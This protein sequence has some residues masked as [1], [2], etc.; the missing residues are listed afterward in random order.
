MKK[1]KIIPALLISA[2]VL[3][4]CGGTNATTEEEILTA[5]KVTSVKPQ[6]IEK[7]LVYNGKIE[8]VEQVSV[9]SKLSGTVTSTYKNVGDN[10][11]QGDVL[12]AIDQKDINN[13]INQAK[14]QAN[15]A[16][17][18]VAQAQN[19]YNNVTGAQY[20]QT[21]LQL[22]TS[23]STL[24]NSLKQAQDALNLAKTA[25][26]NA[27]TL[28]S[29]GAMSKTEF[30]RT[31][32]SY[33][34]AVIA[35]DNTT[36]QLSQA[37]D[38]YN[39]TKNNLVAES[40]NSASIGVNQAKASKDSAELALNI[41]SQNLADTTPKSPIS[42]VVSLKNA[43]EGQMIAPSTVAYTISNIDEVTATV[44]VSENIINTLQVGGTVNV[45]INA[46]N[47]NLTGEI[48]EINPV[49]D[50]TS[51]YPIKI[52]LQNPDHEIKPG[53]FCEVTFITEQS[54]NAI[55]LNRE[56]V[57]RNQDVSYVFVLEGENVVSKE[58]T[59]GID[60]GESIEILSGLKAND[61]VVT[62]GQTYVTD[63]EK[64]NVVEEN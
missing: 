35:V 49:A 18:A 15:S 58:V 19:S 6:H 44:K 10:V 48:M 1:I 8:P 7:T 57:L 22:E 52:K 16:S 26:D 24:E 47:K 30:D 27:K 64:V 33:N 21:L 60:T 38:S 37:K 28:Y 53:M 50:Q 32:Q 25:Y 46:L 54:D 55:V 43:Q 29:A 41:A 40:K 62:A 20:D 11:S 31:E 9:V 56:A 34:Q 13:A 17:I 5:V 63:G 36:K 51:T 12:F 23:I 59:T 14:A 4:S 61:K 3:S 39:I 42:G 45:T 2:M